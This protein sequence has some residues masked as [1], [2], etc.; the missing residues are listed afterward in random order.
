MTI[1][2]ARV[3]IRDRSRSHIDLAEAAS[4]LTTSDEASTDDL[5]ACLNHSGLPNELAQ[6]AIANRFKRYDERLTS[7][8]QVSIG[9]AHRHDRATA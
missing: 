5:M 9:E 1:A 7:A 2:E 3:T 8:A 6:V 4:V